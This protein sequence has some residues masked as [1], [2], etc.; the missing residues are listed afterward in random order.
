MT[1]ALEIFAVLCIAF[2][3]FSVGVSLT[4]ASGGHDGYEVAI[5]ESRYI[6]RIYDTLIRPRPSG[7]PV[8]LPRSGRRRAR[9]TLGRLLARASD[10]ILFADPKGVAIL[11]ARTGV[12][13]C[14]SARFPPGSRAR[15]YSAA[16]RI[17]LYGKSLHRVRR[18]ASFGSGT[19]S[20]AALTAA[21][22]NTISDPLGA[23]ASAGRRIPVRDLLEMRD[24]LIR[25]GTRIDYEECLSSSSP[26]LVIMGLTIVGDF[27]IS[28]AEESVLAAFS[29]T[30]AGVVR[31][32]VL[33][34][35]LLHSPLSDPRIREAL[36]RMPTEERLSHYRLFVREGYSLSSLRPVLTF[37]KSVESGLDRAVSDTVQARKRTLARKTVSE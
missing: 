5:I 12:D 30:D 16:A 31:T 10:R 6:H 34:L 35:A 37:E 1:E 20:M 8:M 32:A 21:V 36:A 25:R 26:N 28:R 29:S 9:R 7:E 27:R 23:I 33:T 19:A 4:L 24:L 2:T 15:R 14:L 13:D 3:V 17:P 18:A 11:A 22:A